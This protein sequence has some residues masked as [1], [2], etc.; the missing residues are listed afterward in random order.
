MKRTVLIFAALLVFIFYVTNGLLAQSLMNSKN[1]ASFMQRQALQWDSISTDYYTGIILGN[2]LLGTNIY[3]ENDQAIRFDIGRTDVTDQQ[4]HIDSLFTGQLLTHPRLP[5]GKMLLKT[6]GVITG[7]KMELDIYNAIA[8][9]TIA[10][11]KGVIYFRCLVPTAPE[12][13]IYIETTVKGNEAINWNFEGEKAISPRLTFPNYGVAPKS[14]PAG[15]LANPEFQLKD[16]AGYT[17]CYQPL[18]VKGEY[19]TLWKQKKVNE[20]TVVQITV[21]YSSD[22]KGVTTGQAISE[23]QSFNNR[24]IHAIME[25]HKDWWH[26]YYQQSFVSIPDGRLEGFYWLQLYKMASA[27]RPGKPMIDLMGPWFTSHTPWPAIWWNLNTQLT[28]SPIFTSNHLELGEPL[29]SSLIQHQQ[30]L[31]NNVPKEWRSDAAAIGR[32]SSY[33]LRSP[34]ITGDLRNGRFEPGNLTWTMFYYYQY[35]LYTQDTVELKT[36]IYPLLKRSVNYLVHLLK[37]DTAGI[38]HLP[39]SQSPEYANVADAHYSLA[40]LKWGLETI[41]NI[42]RTFQL[43]DSGNQKWLEVLEHLVPFYVDETGYMIGKE[44]ALTSSHRHY[45][46]LMQIYPF[47]LVSVEAPENEEL[48]KKSIQHWMGFDKALAGYSFMAASSMSSL[49]KDGNAAYQ[50]LNKFLNKHGT[51]GGLY[52]E[53]GPCFETPPAI[54][55]SLLEML[56]QS[57]DGKIRVFPAIPDLWKD[58]VF[59]DLLAEGAFNVTASRKNG[60]TEFIKVKSLAGGAVV[61]E[62]DIPQNQVQVNEVIKKK[63]IA[64]STLHAKT[65]I[66]ITIAK[67]KEITIRNKIFLKDIFIEPV[68]ISNFRQ[69]YW[70]LKREN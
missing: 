35:Y 63:D 9:G 19:T 28:Y 25:Q 29:F 34:L 36:N 8:T 52:Q 61:I 56:L 12:N 55:N 32:I 41:L 42:N 20:K 22:I 48:V 62:T 23:V 17:I 54:A 39:V 7:A 38:Y 5:I 27:T 49:L 43:N 59:A 6:R 64:I 50:Y 69:N 31:I 70:G 13:I 57:W 65:I 4:T 21:A 47:H 30:N 24:P 18:A 68:P 44:L 58:V 2:G 40:A 60:R 46:H 26:K 1:W 53:A 15:I 33:D 37:I 11:T 66:R 16:T 10:T 67:G 51:A 45:S 14:L 3:K